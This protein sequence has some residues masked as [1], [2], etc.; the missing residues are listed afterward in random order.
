MQQD[1]TDKQ[2]TLP[3][4]TNMKDNC[5]KVDGHESNHYRKPCSRIHSV[6]KFVLATA[7]DK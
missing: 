6:R 4:Q 5:Y 1:K 7:V 3:K 2:R